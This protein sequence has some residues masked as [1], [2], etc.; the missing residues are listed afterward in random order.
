MDLS[1]S[2]SEKVMALKAMLARLIAYLAER[3]LMDLHDEE[4]TSTNTAEVIFEEEEINETS[5]E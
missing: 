2:N 4:E 5:N 1:P 3:R